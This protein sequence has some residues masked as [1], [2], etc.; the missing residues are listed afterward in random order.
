MSLRACSSVSDGVLILAG[1]TASGKTDIAVE[2]AT[3]Y[4]AEIVGADSRQIYRGMPIGTAAPTTEQMARAPHHLVA[5]LAPAQR[6]SAARYASDAIAAAI[7][8]NT[9][10][11]IMWR[12]RS[13]AMRRQAR[14]RWKPSRGSHRAAPGSASRR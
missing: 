6:Y 12:L 5:F 10:A 1:A 3:T 14:W 7:G 11:R 4:D 8:R 13:K 9:F 2:L